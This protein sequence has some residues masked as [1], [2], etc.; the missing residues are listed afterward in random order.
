MEWS[1]PRGRERYDRYLTFRGVPEA[2][3]ARWKEALVLFLK[4]L[5][6][7]YDRPMLLKSPPHT[8]RVRLLLEL[9]PDARFLHI[10]RNPYTV[11]LSTRHLFTELTRA[12]EFQRPAPAT[13]TRRSSAATA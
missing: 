13:S 7:K 4:K 11:F 2:D 3:V 9:F 5:T 1:F 12:L 6:Y 8:A 10:R